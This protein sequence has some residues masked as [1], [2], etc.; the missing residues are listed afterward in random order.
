MPSRR[1]AR[2]KKVRNSNFCE[3]TKT[4][5]NDICLSKQ[6]KCDTTHRVDS[7]FLLNLHLDVSKL[8]NEN[9]SSLL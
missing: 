6:N 1:K 2:M 5:N 7:I 3:I 8:H 4:R 9:S